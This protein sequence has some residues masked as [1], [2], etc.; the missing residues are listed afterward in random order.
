MKYI[1]Y[2]AVLEIDEQE[3]TY[4]FNFQ[5][6]NVVSV[7]VSIEK[8]F[9]KACSDFQSYVDF[10]DK[11]DITLPVATTY[12]ECLKM[13]PKRHAMLFR[14]KVDGGENTLTENELAYKRLIQE[15]VE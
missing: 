6:L 12:E 11:F 13:N 9:L 1:V 10:A 15:M 2:P 3:R 14:A 7:G 5:D 8:A 4:I